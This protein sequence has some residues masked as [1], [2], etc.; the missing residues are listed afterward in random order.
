MTVVTVVRRIMQPLQQ[1]SC[2]LSLKKI[3]LSWYFWKKKFDTSDNRGD[4]LR[5]AFCDSCDVF[6]QFHS[7]YYL[8]MGKIHIVRHIFHIYG[9]KM[10]RK[11]LKTGK[12][13]YLK[14][15]FIKKII[16]FHLER[17]SIL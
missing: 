17:L 3:E 8:K 4:V 15:S 14:G 11:E 10:V 12:E 6:I 5:A 16:E 7:F 9:S 2:N 1:K 13:A